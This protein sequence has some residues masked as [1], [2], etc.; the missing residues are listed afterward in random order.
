MSN[1]SIGENANKRR[2]KMLR[3]GIPIGKAF[4]ISLRLH[5][6]WF[7]IFA[8]VTWAL[9]GSYFPSTYPT[10]SLSA[11][12]AA[13]LITSV[14]FFGSVLVHELMH[15]IVAQRQG[16]SV[17]SITLFIFGGVSQITSEPKQPKDEFR[18]AI[19]GP[20]SSLLIGG[21]LFG[22]YFGLRDVDTFA[23]QFITAIAYWLGYINLLLGAFN[24]IPGFPL[25]GGR[26]FRSLLWWRSGNLKRATRTASNI[27]RAVGFIFIFVGI[28][29]IF[30]GN[31]VNGIWL[32][33]IGWFLESAAV[34]SYQQLLLQDMLKGHVVREVMSSDCAVIPPDTT[35]D[36]LV[37]ENILTSG[38]RC[39]PVVSDSQILGL[40]T[41]H[42][43]KAVPREQWR[44]ETVR[45][46]MTP[47]D[48]LKWVR[49]DEELSSILRI[50]TEDDINQVPVVQDGKIVGMVNRE[51]LLNFVNIRSGLGI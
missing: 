41:L 40:M 51:D 3:G 11:R 27:G 45:E 19:I 17:Q 7:F 30:T 1:N 32:A 20:L 8:L 44:T 24:L 16:I 12:I 21:V 2:F 29:L 36:H 18:M 38:R 42:N 26:V 14:L 31:W 47:F 13:G 48:K 5:Y 6:S 34:G 9:A 15:S 25:D 46:A 37:H 43:V 23:A 49:P 33:L 10:W 35:I 22:I 39:F 28:W 50:L 4:G